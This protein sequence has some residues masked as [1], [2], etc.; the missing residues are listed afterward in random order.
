MDQ[1]SQP[2]DDQELEGMAQ[3]IARWESLQ[4]VD[5]SEPCLIDL[6]IVASS[7]PVHFVSGSALLVFWLYQRQKA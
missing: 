4:E 1:D 5:L 6:V 3:G 2:I 7:D